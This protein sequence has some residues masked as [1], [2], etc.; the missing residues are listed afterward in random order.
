MLVIGCDHG[1]YEMKEAIIRYFDKERIAYKDFGTFSTE[2][3]DYSDIGFEVAKAVSEGRF[4]TGII[5]CGTGIGVSI[6]ANKV[7]GV[8]AALCTNSYMAR[9][10]REHNNANILALGGRVLGIDHAID[11]VKVFLDTPFSGEERHS[12]RIDKIRTVEN[13]GLS[14]K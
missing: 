13:G 9:M 6:T 10:A 12:R 14:S 5:I 1:G 11:I 8:R 4:E 7:K 2:S 3:V